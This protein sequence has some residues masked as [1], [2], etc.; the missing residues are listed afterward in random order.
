M[1][2][3]N[4][5]TQLSQAIDYIKS[6]S[7]IVEITPIKN[8]RSN[9]QNRALH[10][11][12]SIFAEQLNEAGYYF[13]YVDIFGEVIEYPQDKDTVKEFIWR[14][15]QKQMLRIESTTKL[16][17]QSIN[18]MLEALTLHYGQKGIPINFPCEFEFYLKSLGYEK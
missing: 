18:L 16:T 1:K 11:F 12:F 14:P 8:T 13:R 6:L 17:T 3:F 15:L 9:Q 4:L 7:G 2:R 5:P 10:L